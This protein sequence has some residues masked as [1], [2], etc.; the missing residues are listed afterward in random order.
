MRIVH[1][2]GASPASFG[3][4]D[5]QFLEMNGTGAHFWNQFLRILKDRHGH[6]PEV[7]LETRE[8]RWKLVEVERLPFFFW[9][10]CRLSK[11]VSVPGGFAAHV[12]KS[13]PGLF[14]FYGSTAN[15]ISWLFSAALRARR[16]PY[17]IQYHG[18]PCGSSLLERYFFGGG[19][20]IVA[21]LQ[22]SLKKIG[23]RFS[24]PPERL[25]AIPSG[26][27]ENRFSPE[28]GAGPRGSSI[29]FAGRLTK[30]K[31]FDLAVS[32][33]VSLASRFP[34]LTFDV[35]GEFLGSL[36]KEETLDLL[37][38]SRVLER[39]KFRG[40]IK[41]EEMPGFYSTNAILLLPSQSESLSR[42]TIE[43]MMCGTVPV[44]LEGSGGPSTFI[45]D[46]ENGLVV[47][48]ENIGERLAE[49]ISR[50]DLLQ[51]LS[52][53]ARDFALKNF[54]LSSSLKQAEKLYGSLAERKKE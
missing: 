31:G 13:P 21:P 50:E 8:G 5:A 44:A 48:R 29:C 53:N 19:A 16:I 28:A 23:S 12:M 35:A 11:N 18:G 22:D 46:K 49:L 33:F 14:V 32:T 27:D 20:A 10:S 51:S 1:Y 2:Y 37:G 24:I 41:P 6:S 7:H 15:S 47:T 40:W 17:V 39:V 3:L 54:S 38:K 43:A 45:T 42:A 34:K 30:E 25:Y 9:P 4:T 36:A 26:I 52:R